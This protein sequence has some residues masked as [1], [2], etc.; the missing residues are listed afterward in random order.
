M[1]VKLSLAQHTETIVTCRFYS[2]AV[3]LSKARR[4]REPKMP[5]RAGKATKGKIEEKQG[6]HQKALP[7]QGPPPDLRLPPT[8]EAISSEPF[9]VNNGSANGGGGGGTGPDLSAVSRAEVGSTCA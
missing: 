3:G 1:K 2:V 6:R 7:P 4:D 9:T 8:S 5:L